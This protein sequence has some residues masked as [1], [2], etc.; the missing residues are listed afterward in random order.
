VGNNETTSSIINLADKSHYQN[1][2]TNATLVECF[3]YNI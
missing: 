3:F 2:R 1:L